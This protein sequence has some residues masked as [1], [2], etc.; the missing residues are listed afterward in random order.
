MK[1][2]ST[3][4]LLMSI[5]VSIAVSSCDKEHEQSP[6]IQLTKELQSKYQSFVIGDW[7]Y[8]WKTETKIETSYLSLREDGSMYSRIVYNKREEVMVGGV[9][10]LT[11]WNVIFDEKETG[12]WSL[13][14]NE[15]GPCLIVTFIY[16]NNAASEQ[17]LRFESA[18]ENEM[19]CQG[20]MPISENITYHRV[21]EETTD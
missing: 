3:I 2:K 16:S 20:V 7:K 1:I 19:I 18:D 5:V 14:Y 4:M 12:R 15:H 9:P 10:T 17:I 21:I 11:D 6:Y 8:E 13:K